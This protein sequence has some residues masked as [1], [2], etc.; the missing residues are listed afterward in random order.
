M[1]AP[2]ALEDRHVETEAAA[3]PAVNELLNQVHEDCQT[4]PE[5]YLSDSLV[6]F[7]GE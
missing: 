2:F 1:N 4:A 3:S 6:P 7:G 5:Q